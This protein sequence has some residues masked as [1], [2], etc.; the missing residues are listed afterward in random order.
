VLVVAEQTQDA[1]A[2]RR[3]IREMFHDAQAVTIK[4]TTR[5]RRPAD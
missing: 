5:V 3:A 4:K 1:I 2:R